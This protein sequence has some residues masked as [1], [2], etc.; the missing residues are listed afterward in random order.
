MAR[1][2]PTLAAQA[3]GIENQINFAGAANDKD[4]VQLLIDFISNEEMDSSE[5]RM[6]MDKMDPAA[7]VG[8]YV[9][10]VALKASVT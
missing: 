5:L 7:R 3:S 2:N 6:G 9:A 8:L 10:L 4:R 1:K